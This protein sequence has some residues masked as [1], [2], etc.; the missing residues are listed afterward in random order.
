VEAGPGRGSR[1]P[2]SFPPRAGRSENGSGRSSPRT[3]STSRSSWSA[4]TFPWCGSCSGRTLRWALVKGRGNYVSIRRLHLAAESAPHPVRGRSERRSWRRWEWSAKRTHGR[5]ALGPALSPLRGL[6]GGA[7]GRGHLHGGA[8]PHFQACFYQRAAGEAASADLL[9]ANH[10][11]LFADVSRSERHGELVAQSAVLPAYRHVILDEGHNVEDAA[12]SH[13]GAEV[14]RTGLFRILDRLDRKGRGRPRRR[15]PLVARIQGRMRPAAPG[16]PRRRDPLLRRP[17]AAGSRSRRP[18]AASPGPGRRTRPVRDPALLEESG[19]TGGRAPSAVKRE[20]E[21]LRGRIED[22]MKL[23][24][25]ARGPPARSP[26]RSSGA[27][28]GAAAALRA[29]PGSRAKTGSASSAGSKGGAVAGD[30]PLRNVVPGGGSG[31]A[32]GTC[33]GTALFAAARDGR[34]DFGDPDRRT[35]WISASSGGGWGSEECRNSVAGGGASRTCTGRG[36]GSGSDVRN[37]VGPGWTGTHPPRGAPESSPRPWVASPFDYPA[38]SSPR[39][40][41]RPPGPRGRVG[42]P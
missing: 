38:Q 41:H 29:G 21:E 4:R 2:I 31:G 12:T 37:G 30:A 14:T 13:L 32:R 42:L 16:G 22:G 18:G 25:A 11:L 9:V 15:E 26:V 23:M 39:G 33:C 10:A 17:G 1:S 3:R 28:K 5:L 20:V 7:L 19:P 27:W 8:L 36:V 24:R 6:G 40:A 34:G 35:G